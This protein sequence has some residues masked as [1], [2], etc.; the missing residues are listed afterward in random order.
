MGKFIIRHRDPE[1][2]PKT[3]WWLNTT[4]EEFAER[5]KAREPHMRMSAFGRYNLSLD[6]AHGWIENRG[7][8]LSKKARDTA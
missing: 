8:G 4:R 2:E 1:A 5:R 6:N 3:S 7:D